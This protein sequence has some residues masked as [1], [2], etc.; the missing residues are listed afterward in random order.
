MTWYSLTT[1]NSAKPATQDSSRRTTSLGPLHEFR[2]SC[3]MRRRIWRTN[4]GKDHLDQMVCQA[5]HSYEDTI[6][7]RNEFY[8][9]IAEE[10]M[11]AS[12][13]TK[14]TSTPAHSRGNGLVER[15]K[16]T[17]LTILRVYS[18]RRM[19]DRVEH[20]DGDLGAYNSTRHATRG[21]SNYML[22]HG[23]EILNKLS[24]ISARLWI[25]GRVCRT[26]TSQ[27][28]RNSRVSPQGHAPGTI[29]AETEIWPSPRS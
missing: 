23:A 17:L 8:C 29:E 22:Q 4:N 2:W 12:Q 9:E 15:Q 27:V 25:Q 5:W 21:F 6:W 3:P 19:P 20:I 11:K 24:F 18:V 28:T 13:V 26:P 7:Q 16:R 10:L 1:W 14:M